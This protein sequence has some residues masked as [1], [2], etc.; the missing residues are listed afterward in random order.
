MSSKFFEAV[1]KIFYEN[2]IM[3]RKPL[4][5]RS[6]EESCKIFNVDLNLQEDSRENHTYLYLA[7]DY[8]KRLLNQIAKIRKNHRQ[9]DHYKI[10]LDDVTVYISCGKNGDYNHSYY[11]PENKDI[12]VY[13][14]NINTIKDDPFFR[15]NFMHEITHYLS[16]NENDDMLLH[17]Y[18]KE[19]EDVL[20]Y[21]TQ[22]T[23]L[24]LNKIAISDFIFNQIKID[25]LRNMNTMD[26]K[27]QDALQRRIDQFINAFVSNKG[28]IYHEFFNYLAKDQQ[29]FKEFYE[30]L[31]ET[32][33]TYIEHS[34]SEAKT[35]CIL[36]DMH[37]GQI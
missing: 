17:N 35:Y 19:D 3:L 22:P 24:L 31:Q 26:I 23:E 32:I 5:N 8:Y 34:F 16:Q 21:Y 27:S 37:S 25:V 11:D 1:S 20:K 33:I 15:S 4:A 9:T 6:Y 2:A 12:E 14:K 30:E 13:A 7:H 28:F 29:L 36:N 18:T 10:Q